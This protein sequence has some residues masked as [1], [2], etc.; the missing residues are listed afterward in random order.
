MK[1]VIMHNL[2]TKS[3]HMVMDIEKLNSQ[4]NWWARIILLS[5]SAY[6]SQRVFIQLV[7][8]GVCKFL[9]LLEM[10]RHGR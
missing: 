4:L 7:Y 8:A 5:S 9:F 3:D 10:N 6:F 2:Q 1:V